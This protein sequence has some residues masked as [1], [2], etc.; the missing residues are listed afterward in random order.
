MYIGLQYNVYY[1]LNVDLNIHFRHPQIRVNA[2][3]ITV[4]DSVKVCSPAEGEEQAT[5]GH[6]AQRCIKPRQARVQK[7]TVH[8]HR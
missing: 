3:G 4:G 1:L 6:A 8:R 7:I 2:S 5:D